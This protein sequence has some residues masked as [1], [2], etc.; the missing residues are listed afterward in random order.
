MKKNKITIIINKPIKDVFEFT[1]NPKNT[2]TW[3]LS[4]KEEIAEEYPPKLGTIYKN[5]SKTSN[6]NFYKVIGFE[7]NKK[8]T[9]S[10]L[11]GNYFVRYTYKELDNNKTKMEYFEWIQKGELENPFT[12]D[13]LEKL[14]VV[15]EKN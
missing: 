10:D 4:I 13:I 11:N 15:L 12:K 3:I 6:W 5:R 9:L 1:I 14:K 2:P 7:K 8:F